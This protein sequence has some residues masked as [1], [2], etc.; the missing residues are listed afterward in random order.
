MGAD[1]AEDLAVAEEDDAS[2]HTVGEEK[3]R[4][5]ETLSGTVL[6]YVVKGAAGQETL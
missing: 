5:H 4:G 6:R 1:V 3:D 2:R